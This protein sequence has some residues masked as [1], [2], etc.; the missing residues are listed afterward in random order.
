MTKLPRPA[1]AWRGCL[2]GLD[3]EHRLPWLMDVPPIMKQQDWHLLVFSFYSGEMF[4]D[5]DILNNVVAE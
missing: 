1:E 2:I 5:V 3:L 4:S